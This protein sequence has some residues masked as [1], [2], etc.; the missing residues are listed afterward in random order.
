MQKL[1]LS[2]FMVL[3]LVPIS[4]SFSQEYS[5]NAPTLSVSLHNETPFVY[6][7]SDGYTV[8]VGS[9]DNNNS[10]TSVTNVQIQV[11]FYD[12]FDP[13]PIE[14]SVGHTILE[15]IPPNGQSPFAIRS[16]N[17]NP[18]ITEASISLLGFDSSVEKQKGLSV[19]F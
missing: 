12:E 15:V 16:E 11:K 18:N 9:V 19:Y 17:P 7:D 8:V 6:Q 4:Q 10:L 5:D 3:L 14:V 2:I 13:N 1:I